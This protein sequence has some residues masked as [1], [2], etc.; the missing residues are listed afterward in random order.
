M[1]KTIAT[2]IL[3]ITLTACAGSKTEMPTNDG[4]GTDLMRKSPC[5]GAERSPCAPLDFD[6]RGFT[7]IG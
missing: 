3:T 2:L 5:V 1:I 7:W 4:E 6:G